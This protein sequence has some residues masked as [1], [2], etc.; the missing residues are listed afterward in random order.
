M[1]PNPFHRENIDGITVGLPRTGIKEVHV[2]TLTTR[3][4]RA[5]KDSFAGKALH[6]KLHLN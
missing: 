3:L 4:N 5:G 2:R 6:V 1:A